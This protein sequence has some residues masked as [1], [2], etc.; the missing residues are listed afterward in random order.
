MSSLRD[1]QLSLP[2]QLLKARE[3]AMA[4]F[5]PMLR[6]HDLTE[7]QWRVIRVLA[8][9]PVMDASELAARALLLAP[10]LSRIIAHLERGGLVKR[11]LDPKDQ[12][13]SKLKLTAAGRKKFAEVGPDSESL[14]GQ[15]ESRFGRKKLATLYGLLSELNDAIELTPE[16]TTHCVD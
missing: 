11:T 10:S 7:Q 14:Y 2:M 4:H 8:S 6:S 5:R 3:A 13:R 12:R 9:E 1:I 16:D 15:I